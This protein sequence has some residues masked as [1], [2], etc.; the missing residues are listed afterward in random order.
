[1]NNEI[2]PKTESDVKRM[3]SIA[4]AVAVSAFT[5][6]F[7]GYS[8]KDGYYVFDNAESETCS[9]VLS[10]A[11]GVMKLGAGTLTLSA[12]NTFTG[13]LVISNGTIQV[14]QGK[15]LGSPSK[16]VIAK[17]GVLDVQETVNT[18]GVTG[19]DPIFPAS[20][21]V[22]LAGKIVRNAGFARNYTFKNVRL[23]DDAEVEAAGTSVTGLGGSTDSGAGIYLQGHKLKI[24][25]SGSLQFGLNGPVDPN[26]G[27][28]DPSAYGSVEQVA[29][30]ATLQGL[31]SI[32]GDSN[33]V[34]TISGGATVSFWDTRH[35]FPWTLNVIGTGT[36]RSGYGT[37]NCWSGPV[38]VADGA[39]LTASLYRNEASRLKVSGPVKVEGSG[40]LAVDMTA[41]DGNA[42][43][44][45]DRVEGS[46]ASKVSVNARQN[47]IVVFSNDFVL[48][49]GAAFTKSE[50]NGTVEFA[51]RTN[52]FGKAVENIM[53]TMRF[54]SSD[55]VEIPGNLITKTKAE[56]EFRDA[57]YVGVSSIY[58][59]GGNATP[60]HLAITNTAVNIAVA[61]FVPDYATNASFVDVYDDSSLTNNGIRIGG[62]QASATTTTKGAYRQWC[63]EVTFGDW[64]QCNIGQFT[65]N[66]GYFALN[67]G[68]TKYVG[69]HPNFWVGMGGIGFCEIRGGVFRHKTVYLCSTNSYGQLRMTGG[70]LEAHTISLGNQTSSAAAPGG[71]GVLALSGS[72]TVAS[73]GN[74]ITQKMAVS[75][76]YTIA[77]NDG[78]RLE[79]LRIQR[80]Y[81]GDDSGR[82]HVSVNGGVLSHNGTTAGDWYNSAQFRP[83]SFLV[84]DGGV[85]FE[86]KM[87]GNA[88]NNFAVMSSDLAAPEG[89][90][91][92]AIALPTAEGFSSEK[93][94]GP[95]QIR[96]YGDGT[97]A[98]ACV[99]YDDVLMIPTN[100][101]VVAK[102]TGY[103]ASGTTA[104]MAS[105]DGKTW[106]DCE[107]TVAPVSATG[108]GLTKRG[109]QK[110]ELTGVNTYKG[111][112]CIEGGTLK[113]SGEYSLPVGSGLFVDSGA[114]VDLGGVKRSVP[115]LGGAGTVVGSVD[116]SKGIAAVCAETPLSVTGTLTFGEG[117]T[118]AV[119]NPEVLDP[120]SLEKYVLVTAGTIS[121]PLPMLTGLEGR[122]RLSRSGNN[123]CVGI[124]RGTVI[125]VR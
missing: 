92:T 124:P 54:A 36:L 123:L 61:M 71:I 83:E 72:N 87:T 76:D 24:G 56:I 99:D 23:T 52:I 121:G 40:E 1:M 104:Q 77:V 75:S 60:S 10:G 13:P 55:Y 109:D 117:A 2:M 115:T 30:T 49:T 14:A 27:R 29:G 7:A 48:A 95:A 41:I 5:S 110:L 53:G 81:T 108:R 84:Q 42:I 106:Y 85:V 31:S 118:F 20:T 94:M 34:W 88:T 9:E 4:M 37:K 102:G 74:R 79:S 26:S 78:A 80:D 25:G 63:G 90:V 17:D 105:A 57:G 70:R 15:Y 28:A 100:I 16:V 114:T 96:I 120:D 97:D 122:W 11:S 8:V 59:R 98:V 62:N 44:F 58:L 82:I 18:F 103:A 73:L 21:P 22:E 93:Y 12:E 107:V 91:V 50:A 67:G 45:A 38:T 39:K 51:G 68:E 3:A 69:D 116:V 32:G 33:N 112:T 6:V 46:A 47:S 64:S 101:T 65:G 113:L 89:Y 86:P 35:D 111:D 125:F 19:N 66:Y 119:E 43:V